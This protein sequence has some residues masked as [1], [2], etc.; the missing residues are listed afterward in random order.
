MKK[1]SLWKNI[2]IGKIDKNHTQSEKIDEAFDE[3]NNEVV[4]ISKEVEESLTSF[5]KMTNDINYKRK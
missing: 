2:I 4:E 3:I 1:I 5:G